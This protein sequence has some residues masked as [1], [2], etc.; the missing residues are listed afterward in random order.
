MYMASG[1]F[2]PLSND[3]IITIH[4]WLLLASPSALRFICLNVLGHSPCGIA[5]SSYF[6]LE[7]ACQGT[8][9]GSREN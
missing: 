9:A 1:F 6:P 4:S 8:Q 3:E 2:M 5:Y 7:P